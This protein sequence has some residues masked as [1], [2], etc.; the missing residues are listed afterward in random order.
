MSQGGSLQSLLGV[1]HELDDTI[2]WSA[3]F[4]ILPEWR[5]SVANDRM[6]LPSDCDHINPPLAGR[7]RIF[8]FWAMTSHFA[9]L[10][11]L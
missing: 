6:F 4:I 9:I 11:Q 7:S 2:F 1:A 3:P 8:L 5:H 10:H